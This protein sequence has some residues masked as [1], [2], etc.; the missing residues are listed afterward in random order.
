MQNYLT[1]D[2][3]KAEAGALG[4]FLCGVS[5]ISPSKHFSVFKHWIAENLHAKM[6]Y[7]A[8]PDT[9]AK[10]ADPRL[11]MPDAR[12]LI[13]LAFPYFPAHQQPDAPSPG[14]HGRVAAYAWGLDYHDILPGLIQQLV[15]R[16]SFSKMGVQY[17]IF[18][19]SAPILERGYAAQAGLGWIGKNSCLIHPKLGSYFLLAEIL[20]DLE[21][22]TENQPIQDHCGTCQ[23]CI[24][25]CP[26]GCI[27]P[28]RTLDSS[29][30][31]SYLTIENKAETPLELQA[32][33]GNWVFGCD[34][35]QIVCPWNQHFSHSIEDS[36]LLGDTPLLWVDLA[37]ELSGT[38]Q[39]FEVEYRVRPISRTHHTGWL[40]NC[41]VAAG[42]LHTLE[43]ISPLVSLFQHHPEPM[44]RIQAAQ[45]L[46]RY[47][48]SVY[49]PF[50]VQALNSESDLQVRQTIQE[51]LQPTS[52]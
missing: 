7:L 13:S 33:I 18:T 26:T 1:P 20:T 4:F 37:K 10:R 34:I 38:S 14:A 43:L 15:D 32:L 22:Q 24:Q 29:R 9:L 49:C 48:I 21:L 51:L 12:T 45:A 42:N 46:A 27:R 2:I 39:D 8:R 41:I 3:L 47:P 5:N 23:R 36:P 35:C 44:I 31:I 11:L 17:K 25:A 28:D 40:R 50:L 16:L 6:S 52:R 30:C 19:D